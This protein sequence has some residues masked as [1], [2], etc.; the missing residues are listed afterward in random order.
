MQEVPATLGSCVAPSCRA[1]ALQQPSDLWAGATEA[2]RLRGTLPFF[3]AAAVAA[4]TAWSLVAEEGEKLHA[5]EFAGSTRSGM[6]A[7]AGCHEGRERPQSN[8]RRTLKGVERVFSSSWSWAMSNQ[9]SQFLASPVA[10]PVS[11]TEMPWP[12][13]GGELA[14]PRRTTCSSFP[15]I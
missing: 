9:N 4:S 12:A 1:V 11:A 10:P 15:W 2:L 13:S 5:M 14:R 7:V 6:A 3:T 8:D